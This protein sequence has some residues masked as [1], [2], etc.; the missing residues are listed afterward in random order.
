MANWPIP[1]KYPQYNNHSTP[2]FIH[3]CSCVLLRWLIRHPHSHIV[4]PALVEPLAFLLQGVVWVHAPEVEVDVLF[5]LDRIPL[6]IGTNIRL[7]VVQPVMVQ[8]GFS[9]SHIVHCDTVSLSYWFGDCFPG[10]CYPSIQ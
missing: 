5:R 8:L 9:Y 2:Q 7:L 3:Y 10:S 1:S 6:L 4:E